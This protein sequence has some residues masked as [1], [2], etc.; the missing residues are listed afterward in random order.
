MPRS[1]QNESAL[2]E[3]YPGRPQ[4]Q[5]FRGAG[6]WEGWWG[7]WTVLPHRVRRQAVHTRGFLA[8]AL[9]TVSQQSSQST[10]FHEDESCPDPVVCGKLPF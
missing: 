2:P 4:G 1:R 8:L 3:L 5:S 6:N 7:P 10:K 9:F